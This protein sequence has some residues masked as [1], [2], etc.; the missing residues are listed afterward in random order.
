MNTFNYENYK[1]LTTHAQVIQSQ[2]IFFFLFA[3]YYKNKIKKQ[4][5]YKKII[6][7]FAHFIQPI[8]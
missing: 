7:F 2:G 8:F 6:S 3:F 1:L 4:F 5:L